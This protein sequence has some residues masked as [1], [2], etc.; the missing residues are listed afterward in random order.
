MSDHY[1]LRDAPDAPKPHRDL[2]GWKA[3]QYER[4]QAAAGAGAL[5]AQME[6]HL[7]GIFSALKAPPVNDVLG[8]T[9]A[10]IP[11]SGVWSRSWP[12]AFASVSV[13]NLGAA[14]I[15]VTQANSINAPSEGPGVAIVAGGYSRVVAL[16]GTELAI[17]GPPGTPLDVTVYARPREPSSGSCGMAATPLFASV[18]EA[19]DTGAQLYLT[20][21][22]PTQTCY[23][24]GV[25]LEPAG[26]PGL[27][28]IQGLVGGNVYSPANWTPSPP[29]PG[30]QGA[31][32]EL[33]V[34]STYSSVAYTATI[35]GFA[36]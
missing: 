30:A 4:D 9:A 2:T 8:Q 24:A 29:L 13:A 19:A 25:A 17:W 35:W 20:P 16:R 11:A 31:Q 5:L 3:R 27:A 21:P 26:T 6:A 36:V 22:S 10:I 18:E 15:T 34:I 12:Q 14:P 28:I 1:E 32:I 23:L 33:L 7:G